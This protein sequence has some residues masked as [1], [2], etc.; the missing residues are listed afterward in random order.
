VIDREPAHWLRFYD[1]T[2]DLVPL[3]EESAQQ[4]ANQEQERADQAEQQVELEREARLA[5]IARLSQMGL[6]VEQIAE[7]L[8]LPLEV[9]QSG[10][11]AD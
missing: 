9:A 3:P 4:R 1:Q 2:H 7:A 6:T 5:A 10:V 11:V 8:S